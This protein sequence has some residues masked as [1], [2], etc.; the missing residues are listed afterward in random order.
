MN[1]ENK[2]DS[3]E[4]KEEPEPE[5]S[6]AEKLKDTPPSD[7]MTRGAEKPE[8]EVHNERGMNTE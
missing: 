5:K 4:Q 7:S 2:Q 3:P 6:P 8:S 1:Q